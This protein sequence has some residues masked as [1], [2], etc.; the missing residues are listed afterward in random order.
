MEHSMRYGGLM[1]SPVT[2]LGIGT[3]RSAGGEVG[4]LG[5]RLAAKSCTMASIRTVLAAAPVTWKLME[6]SNVQLRNL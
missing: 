3:M 1:K 2:G 4:S 6:P 5:G